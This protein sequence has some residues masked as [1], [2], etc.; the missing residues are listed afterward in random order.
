MHQSYLST[1]GVRIVD[2]GPSAA[3]AAPI[4]ISTVLLS[5][6]KRSHNVLVLALL[7]D[8]KCGLASIGVRLGQYRIWI[9]TRS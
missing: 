1:A 5:L 4:L 9:S 2:N 3:N 8:F 7:R 6:K